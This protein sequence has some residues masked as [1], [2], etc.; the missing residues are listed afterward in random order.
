MY[1][2]GLSLC[3]VR[4]LYFQPFSFNRADRR[5]NHRHTDA[6]DRLLT[7]LPSPW[8][9]ISATSSVHLHWH[10]RGKLMLNVHTNWCPKCVPEDSVSL[11]SRSVE[12][13]VRVCMNSITT[14]CTFTGFQPLSHLVYY[15]QPVFQSHCV[16]L[17]SLSTDMIMS[18]A[19]SKSTGWPRLFMTD[20]SS[21]D[22][23]LPSPSLS[24]RR[25]ASANTAQQH[26]RPILDHND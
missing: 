9:K 1:R 22:V 17:P 5:Q 8:V 14:S 19:C 20:W 10:S 7:R 15:P 24:N 12:L 6:D 13:R 16:G 25:N 3:Q 21:E 2:D 23:M 4:W 26:H 11:N 18:D